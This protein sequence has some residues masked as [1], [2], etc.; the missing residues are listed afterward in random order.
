LGVSRFKLDPSLHAM[1]A[2]R[3][4]ADTHLPV[5]EPVPLIE[6]LANRVELQD[7]AVREQIATLAQ[8]QPKKGSDSPIRPPFLQRRA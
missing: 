4:N 6:I 2:P 1:V 5:N 3:V 7:V 8:Q